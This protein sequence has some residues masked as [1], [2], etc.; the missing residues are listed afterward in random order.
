MAEKRTARTGNRARRFDEA[1]LPEVPDDVPAFEGTDVP[2]QY[3][4]DYMSRIQNL[5]AFLRDFPEVR[6]RLELDAIR[7]PVK[8]EMPVHGDRGRV[9]S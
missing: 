2:V 5:Y 9:S 3:L 8:T 6:P 1:R 4:F 7:Q